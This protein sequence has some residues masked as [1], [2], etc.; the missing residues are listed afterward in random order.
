[1]CITKEWLGIKKNGTHNVIDQSKYNLPKYGEV[2]EPYFF[3]KSPL[4]GIPSYCF[5]EF[6]D[7][8]GPVYFSAS[9]FVEIDEVQKEI[10]EALAAPTP[11]KKFVITSE[12]QFH[13]MMEYG[14]TYLKQ[15]L[16][17]KFTDN[18]NFDE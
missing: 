4:T 2:Y 14:K 13:A 10:T 18:F 11:I 7:N 5:K 17:I 12:E 3:G 6:D 1:M 9:H 16:T 15:K 8:I